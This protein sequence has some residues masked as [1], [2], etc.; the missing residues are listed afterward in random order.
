VIIVN[1]AHGR[2][3]KQFSNLAAG[4]GTV[5]IEGGTFAAGTYNCTL[6]IDGNKMDTK[7]MVLTK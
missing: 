7:E 1:D 4:F 2:M 6:V 3:M 5:T